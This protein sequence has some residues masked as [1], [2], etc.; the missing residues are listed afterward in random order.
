MTEQTPQFL[1]VGSG[2]ARRRIAYLSS[3]AGTAPGLMW[4]QGLK[5][6]MVSTKA[7]A[8]AEWSDQRGHSLLRFDYSGHGR[9]EGRFED[10]TI[11]RW[12]EE[13]E[14]AF[15]DLTAGPQLVLGSS[16]GGYLALLLLRRLMATR[17]EAAE[18]I[19][20]VL[21]IAPAWNM[22]EDL[23]WAVMPPETRDAIMRDGVWLRP[24]QYGDPYAITRA[25]IEDGRT[26]LLPRTR[27]D[28]GRPVTIIHGRLDPDVPYL[29]SETLVRLLGPSPVKLIEVPD[30]EHRLS[31]PEDLALMF[32]EIEALMAAG[33]RR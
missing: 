19:R 29:H 1:T 32:R 25:L 13:T 10:G 14:A 5:S 7:T 11:S 24:S 2:A 21:L 9:S 28:P 8:L 3:L 31:R 30:G 20:A 12:L 16:M 22:T 6:E 17:A 15:R 4:L 27:W 33:G 23:M 18:R 26:H